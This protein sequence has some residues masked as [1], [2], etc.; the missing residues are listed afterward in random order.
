[1]E[2]VELTNS[3]SFGEDATAFE[4]KGFQRSYDELIDSKLSYTAI[5]AVQL[6]VYVIKKKYL[7]FYLDDVAK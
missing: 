1:M 6:G 4:D 7:Y 2:I 3:E 5:S